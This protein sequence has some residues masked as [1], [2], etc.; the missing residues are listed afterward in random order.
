[1]AS[2]QIALLDGALEVAGSVGDD[3]RKTTVAL[4]HGTGAIVVSVTSR[5]RQL[6]TTEMTPARATA[7]AALL[8]MAAARAR[9]LGGPT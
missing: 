9:R 1:M 3:E 8:S 4:D 2:E 7:L 5:G 6:G